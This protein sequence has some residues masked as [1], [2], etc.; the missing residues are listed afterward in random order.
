MSLGT[1][2]S[3]KSWPIFQ[4]EAGLGDLQPAF[5]CDFMQLPKQLIP[6]GP[7]LQGGVQRGSVSGEGGHN[8]MN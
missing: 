1:L 5:F 7:L 2:T 4:Q 8:V 6:A 3:L